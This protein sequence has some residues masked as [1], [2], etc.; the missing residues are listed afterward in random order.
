MDSVSWLA[1]EAGSLGYSFVAA[2]FSG[3]LFYG[4]IGFVLSIILLVF[5][6]RRG[7]LKRPNLLWRIGVKLQYL[8]IPVFLTCLFAAFGTARSFQNAVGEWV[9]A[10]TGQLQSYAA[11]Y[12]PTIEE[13]ARQAAAATDTGGDWIEEQI[14]GSATVEGEGTWTRWA[15]EGINRLVIGFVLGQFGL[16]NN[17]AGLAELGSADNL[18]ALQATTFSGIG[19]FIKAGFVETFMGPIYT[20]LMVFFGIASLFSLGEFALFALNRRAAPVVRQGIM[21]ARERVRRE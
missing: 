11:S 10:S 4:F 1:S 16:E 18:L 12:T 19:S 15:Y 21:S 9:D 14:E 17:A 20:T 7:Y 2:L 5:L 6:R 8:F 13:Y 3:G